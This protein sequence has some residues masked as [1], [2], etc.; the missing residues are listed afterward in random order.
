M[1]VAGGGDWDSEG[2]AIHAVRRGVAL[3]FGMAFGAELTLD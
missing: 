2:G 1:G 3:E